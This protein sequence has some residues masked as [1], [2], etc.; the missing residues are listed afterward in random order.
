MA[1]PALPPTGAAIIPRVA[2]ALD[3]RGDPDRS[4][5]HN[6]GLKRLS[7]GRLR[8]W[9]AMALGL[10]AGFELA[11]RVLSLIPGSNAIYVSDDGV[12]FRLRPGV[13][14]A[15]SV[16]NSLGFND[17]EP[18]AP[19][20]ARRV[21]FIG[22][23]FVFGAV[24]RPDN[25]VERF[26]AL[27]AADGVETLNLGIPAAGPENYLGVLRHEPQVRGADLVVLVFFVGNDV[28]QSHPDFKT[29]IWM[30]APR[31]QLRTPW[32]WRASPDY[33]YGTKMIRAG[34]RVA[35]WFLWARL[36]TGEGTMPEEAF[37]EVE[38]DNLRMF[39]REPGRFVEACYQGA[40]A[41]MAEIR[42]EAGRQRLQLVVVLAP[43]QLQVDDGLRAQLAARTDLA[44]FDIDRP[45]KRLRPELEARGVQVLD[46]L[47]AFRA[48]PPHEPLYLPRDTHWN[49]RGNAL[50]ARELYSFVMAR[51]LLVSSRPQ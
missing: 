33:L 35:R 48:R 34:W 6:P 2:S 28:S 31:A 45:Q 51:G 4:L 46:L 18:P 3:A 5:E 36:G 23:S 32:L 10:C 16:T 1:R 14:V 44:A 13:T 21:A 41:T 40:D 47:P 38:R 26:E 29:R 19:S 9:G 17:E 43:D 12:G 25:F 42:A 20:A 37:L 7:A 15:R 22:D 11:L 27:A 8:R 49:E 50:A 24:A 39:R 30:G